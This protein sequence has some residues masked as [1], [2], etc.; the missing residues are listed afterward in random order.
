[1]NSCELKRVFLFLIAFVPS[2]AFAG[3]DSDPV[4]FKS[5]GWSIHRSIDTMTDE[6][7]CTGVY[8]NDYSIQL[9]AN[10]LYIQVRGGVKGYRLRFGEQP[11]EELQLPKE[12]EEQMGVIMIQDDDFTKLLASNRLRVQV[13]T[14]LDSIR[15]YD[16]DLAGITD[17]TKNIRAGCPGKQLGKNLPTKTPSL[18]GDKVIQRLRAKKVSNEIIDY[19][20]SSN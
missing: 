19:A 3:L 1:M 8:K 13:M 16:I 20:C 11:S 2:L 10:A 9:N 15:N 5:G 7:T 12:M 17:A 6:T 18:C 4:V 14:V